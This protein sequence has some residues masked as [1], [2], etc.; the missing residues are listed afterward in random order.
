MY[1]NQ[2]VSVFPTRNQIPI[3]SAV[4]IDTNN[5]YDLSVILQKDAAFLTQDSASIAFTMSC[6][7]VNGDK[8]EA[9]SFKNVDFLYNSR[10]ETLFAIAH[11]KKA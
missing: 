10:G 7:T 3:D 5:T 6:T 11:F 2:T 1:S 9:A 8:T 4:T